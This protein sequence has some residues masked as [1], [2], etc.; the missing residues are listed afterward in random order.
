MRQLCL[1]L[2][3]NR[4]LL[5][6]LLLIAVGVT[7]LARSNVTWPDFLGSSS[8]VEASAV[9]FDPPPPIDGKR[10]YDYLKKI[11]EIGPRTAGSDA[12]TRQREMVKAHFTKMG[13]QVREQ[14]FQTQDP[15]TGQ[16][17]TLVNLIGAWHPD[18][19]E[20]IVI[21]AHYDTRPHPDE[22]DDPVRR[23]MPFLGANDGASGVALEMEIAHHLDKLDTRWGVDLVLFDGEELVYGNSPTVGEYFLG[24]I[25]FAQRYAD[26]VDAGRIKYRYVGG[27][28]L[29]MVGG[30]NLQIKVEPNS[31]R[32]AP[33]LVNQVWRVAGALKAK[34]FKNQMGREVRDD[35]LPLNDK[36]IPTID[37]IDFDYPYWHRADD[38]PK[39]C[40]AE[41]LEEV[42]RVVT[43]WL[44]ARGAAA[45]PPQNRK[46]RR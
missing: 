15:Q 20:R 24:S 22:E 32:F 3:Q 33:E 23:A 38:L 2:T 11:C 29:D 45:P 43:T 18:R 9:M 42:G 34:S 41:S 17:L 27:I 8:V 7:F 10:A 25:E 39:N 12:N 44:A 37:L 31:R 35:H 16:A 4:K 14:P 30:R 26:Q 13:A 1:R 21:G 19:T 46:K 5:A 40:S 6:S 28:V 36:N